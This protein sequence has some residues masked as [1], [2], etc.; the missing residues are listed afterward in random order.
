M[1]QELTAETVTHNDWVP[2]AAPEGIVYWNEPDVALVITAAAGGFPN[3]RSTSE[4]QRVTQYDVGGAPGPK[5]DVLHVTVR[6]WPGWKLP[7][8]YW[9]TVEIP[10][11][12]V[13]PAAS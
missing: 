1:V 10:T 6:V 7:S 3:S 13:I 2:A 12:T 11:D 5:V 9:E 8:E 4:V